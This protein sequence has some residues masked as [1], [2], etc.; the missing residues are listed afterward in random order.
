M[1]KRILS[2]VILTVF[3]SLLAAP[4]FAQNAPTATNGDA[5]DSLRSAAAA[6]LPAGLVEIIYGRDSFSVGAPAPDLSGASGTPRHLAG[7][8]TN[9]DG[10]SVYNGRMRSASASENRL[11]RPYG[12][13]VHLWGVIN[14]RD[15]FNVFDTEQLAAEAPVGIAIRPSGMSAQLWG[16]IY[17]RDGFA[18]G[19]SSCEVC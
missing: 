13:P 16:I 12:M 11:A 19:A 6:S 14:S 10:F 17:G 7:I 8:L 18:A 15:G 1:M 5:T 9:R 2:I 4:G 3:V